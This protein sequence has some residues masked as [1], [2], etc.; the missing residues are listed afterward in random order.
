MAPELVK[1]ITLKWDENFFEFEMAALSYRQPKKNQ[2]LYK[3][4][5]VD[6]EWYY[7]GSDRHGRYSGLPDGNYTLR[8]R[9]SNNDGVWSNRE[10]TLKVIVKGPF[11]RAIWFKILVGL[12]VI[13]IVA[14]GVVRRIKTKEAQRRAAEEHRRD[15]ERT[16]TERTRQLAD[17][18]NQLQI[19]KDAAESANRAKSTFLAN[20]SHELR[21][22]LN[23]ILGFARLTKE[24]PGC[25]S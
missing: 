4:E 10:A 20:M 15:L 24:A 8:V 7:A 12:V 23:A 2:Y 11:W 22:P 14:G 25:N 18:N 13:G 16:V 5:G 6:K 19:A 17:T 3:L 1:E 21:T 9:A